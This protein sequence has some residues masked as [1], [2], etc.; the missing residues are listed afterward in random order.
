MTLTKAMDANPDLRQEYAQNETTRMVLDLVRRFE[1]MPRHASTHAAGV[2]ISN[3]PLT[4]LAPLSRN[5]DCC[6]GSVCQKQCRADRAAQV[7]FFGT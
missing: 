4:D 2:I 5:E 1:G 6:R 7:R 3:E